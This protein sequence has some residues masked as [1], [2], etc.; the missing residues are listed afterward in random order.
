VG[1][2]LP[3]S[4]S[5]WLRPDNCRTSVRSPSTTLSHM[6]KIKK[7]KTESAKILCIT[8]AN[9][10]TVYCLLKSLC[11]KHELSIY[12]SNPQTVSYLRKPASYIYRQT[13]LSLG[14]SDTNTHLKLEYQGG[15]D[16]KT[17]Q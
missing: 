1:I 15:R 5:P 13:S 14:F 12:R 17:I 3:P 4:L 9:F 10:Y 6:G 2:L 8:V 11:K 16:G 7:L